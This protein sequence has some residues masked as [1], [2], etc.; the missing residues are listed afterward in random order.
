M[1]QI[2]S[3]VLMPQGHGPRSQG[4][5][6]FLLQVCL[7]HKKQYSRIKLRALWWSWGRGAISYEQGTPVQVCYERGTP[8]QVCQ[9]EATNGFAVTRPPGHHAGT[10]LSG[11]PSTPLVILL[12]DVTVYSYM[13][14]HPH[15]QRTP[16]LVP[17]LHTRLQDRPRHLF[18]PP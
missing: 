15:R 18:T 11:I 8:V 12:V 10:H 17:H 7:A 16:D 5:Q 4:Q 6:R 9:G 2:S 14:S 3:P 1:R 13:V